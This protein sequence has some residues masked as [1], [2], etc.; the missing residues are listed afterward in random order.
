MATGR[1]RR[2]VRLAAGTA[3]ALGVSVA[4][5]GVSPAASGDLHLTLVRDISPGFPAGAPSDLE[6]AGGNLY[7]AATHPSYGRELWMVTSGGTVKMVR[8]LVADPDGFASGSI[9]SHLTAVGSRVFFLANDGTQD[10]ELYVSDGTAAGTRRVEELNPFGDADITEMTAVGDTL[11][12]L[13]D[14][15]FGRNELWKSDGTASG[16]RRV[17]KWTQVQDPDPHD[18]TEMG[19]S[20]YFSAFRD[21]GTGAAGVYLYKSDGTTAGTM[22]VKR[23]NLVAQ[24][25]TAVGDH[26][27]FSGLVAGNS[28]DAEL[29]TSDGTGAGTHVVRNIVTTA[30]VGS[31]PQQI[32]P[33]GN[34]GMFYFTAQDGA[35]DRELYKSDGTAAG[36]RRVRDI[37]ASQS[38]NPKYLTD[39]DGKV[40]FN[41]FIGNRLELFVSDGTFAGTKQLPT[42][43]PLG[44]TNPQELTA[45][46]GRLFYRGF[47]DATHDQLWTSDGTAAGTRAVG[48]VS[49]SN[50]VSPGDFAVFDGAL[51]LREGS[52]PPADAFGAE[53]YKVTVEP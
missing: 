33:V 21:T 46:G 24:G 22:P 6:V 5:P 35:G 17:Y 30:G 28:S 52:G 50:D 42:S 44:T 53:L 29:W 10:E 47:T 11:Y 36:T 13:L 3:L 32:T 12:F 23:V 19:G 2:I 34:A 43:S 40:F 41:A 26:L 25:L 8:N 49:P 37:N 31:S 4:A 15:T 14:D 1:H 9:P 20:L 45:F 16:T 7:F 48:P 18:L 51:Y 38:S 39:V 27:Y